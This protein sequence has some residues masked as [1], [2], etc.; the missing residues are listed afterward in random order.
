[1]VPWELLAER[2]LT[3]TLSLVTC[4]FQEVWQGVGSLRGAEEI[5]TGS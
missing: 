1:M 4:G 3:D 2:S 5:Q